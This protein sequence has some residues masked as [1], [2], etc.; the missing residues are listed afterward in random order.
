MN[1]ALLLIHDWI[2]DALIA[3]LSTLRG[4]LARVLVSLLAA[5]ERLRS[6][7]D[8]LR[9]RLARMP[10]RERPRY[11]PHERLAI[12]AHQA[13]WKLSFGETARRFVVS[14]MTLHK[15][16]AF[17][18]LYL[19]A[20]QFRRRIRHLSQSLPSLDMSPYRMGADCPSK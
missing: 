17:Q 8:L 6:E 19:R 11:E 14:V 3:W 1:C 5:N 10:G 20:I 13:R 4:P 9:A 7:N 15:D 16:G 12:L 18:A 2:A